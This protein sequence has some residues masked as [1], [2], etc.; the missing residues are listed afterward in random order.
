MELNVILLLEFKIILDI[1][2]MIHL[3]IF[4]YDYYEFVILYLR[5]MT[6]HT[7]GGNILI[8]YLYYNII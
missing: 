7:T 2:Y 5:P 4:S 3:L 1:S 6:R 8:K